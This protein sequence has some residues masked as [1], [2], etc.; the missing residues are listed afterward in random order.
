MSIEK[1]Q[2]VFVRLFEHCLTSRLSKKQTSHAPQH[3]RAK[4]G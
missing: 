2:I 1:A 3:T 4:I